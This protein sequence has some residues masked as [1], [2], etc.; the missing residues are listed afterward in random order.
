MAGEWLSIGVVVVKRASSGPFATH[1]WQPGTILP[2]APP[3]APWTSLGGG[4][5]RESFYAGPATLQLHPAETAHYRDNLESP[6]P[7]VWVQLRPGPGPEGD[8]R[9]EVI[10]ATV[11]PYEGEAMAESVG[12]VVAAFAMPPSIAAEVAAF[13]ASNHVEREFFK[14]KRNRQDPD[15]LGRRAPIARDPFATEE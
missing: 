9:L 4:A 3:V 7:R 1:E 15:S 10:G 8:E 14:R 2:A 6:E 12:D 11:D 5:G 13:F